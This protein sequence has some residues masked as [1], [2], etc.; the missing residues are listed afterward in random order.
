MK[1]EVELGKWSVQNCCSFALP[2]NH[3]SHFQLVLC[4]P[5]CAQT[6]LGEISWHL[7]PVGA[8][9][10][11]SPGPTLGAD[12]AHS[13]GREGGMVLPPRVCNTLSVAP[14]SLASGYTFTQQLQG[15]S[16]HSADE[17]PSSFNSK[18]RK[19]R[20]KGKEFCLG[21]G[22]DGQRH[23]E[24]KE[25]LPVEVNCLGTAWRAS[26]Y[27]WRRRSCSR[28]CLTRNRLKQLVQKQDSAPRVGSDLKQ[29]VPSRAWLGWERRTLCSFLPQHKETE[30]CVPHLPQEQGPPRAQITWSG[31]GRS[32]RQQGW[33]PSA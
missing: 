6:R 14:V 1:S 12:P 25:M 2:V 22:E 7:S 33:A 15:L 11:P 31:T 5:A 4:M 16:A 30:V 18:G 17:P 28:W 32:R 19:C 26:T 29:T 20:G 21:S 9:S 24:G 10:P 3:C 27:S 23:L 13:C 8:P